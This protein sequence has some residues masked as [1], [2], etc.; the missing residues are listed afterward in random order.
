MRSKACCTALVSELVCSMAMVGWASSGRS[1]IAKGIARLEQK[2]A[3][4]QQ[5]FILIGKLI[6]CPQLSD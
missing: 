4:C 3:D 1:K 5:S 6:A 2:I